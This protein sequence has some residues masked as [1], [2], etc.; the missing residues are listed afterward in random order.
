MDKLIDLG[1]TK[2]FQLAEYVC[3]KTGIVQVES[4][5]ASQ[6]PQQDVTPTI[7]FSNEDRMIEGDLFKD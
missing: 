4:K 3:S 5:P 6:Q 7:R 2:L 1:M